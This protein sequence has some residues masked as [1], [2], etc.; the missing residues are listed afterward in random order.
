VFPTRI[1]R[2]VAGFLSAGQTA[3]KAFARVDN[4]ARGDVPSLPAMMSP[5]LHHELNSSLCAVS[6]KTEKVVV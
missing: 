6:W 3:L 4:R 1:T 5:T 2:F